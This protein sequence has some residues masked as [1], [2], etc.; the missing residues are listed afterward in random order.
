MKI[1]ADMK[2]RDVLDIDEEKMV[3]ALSWLSPAFQRLRNPILRKTM[4]GRVTVEQASRIASIPLTEV[5]YVLNLTA[6]VPAEEIANQLKFLGREH[7]EPHAGNAPERPD[8]IAGVSEADA[9]VLFVDVMAEHERGEDP[10]PRIMRAFFDVKSARDKIL[11]IHHPFD[12][13]PLRDLFA[14]EG[15]A[16]WAEER[17]PSHWFVYFYRPAAG[18]E[19]VAHRP[20]FHDM[21]G[22]D[23]S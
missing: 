21:L 7:F 14:R 1:T 15:F 19:P 11:M 9:N 6:G 10:L 23:P 20:L 2:I 4:S 3:E 12:P 22:A 13:I 8:E 18:T 5:L 17:T 16:S